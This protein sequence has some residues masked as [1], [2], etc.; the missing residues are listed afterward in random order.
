MSTDYTLCGMLTTGPLQLG[1]MGGTTAYNYRNLL[2]E[3]AQ[4]GTTKGYSVIVLK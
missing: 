4:N 1:S 3:Q 2:N